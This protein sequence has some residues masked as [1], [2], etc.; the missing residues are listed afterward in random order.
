MSEKSE[1]QDKIFDLLIEL[2]ATVQRT[3]GG[4]RGNIP[5]YF[6]KARYRDDYGQLNVTLQSAFEFCEDLRRDLILRPRMLRKGVSDLLGT[7][8]GGRAYYVECKR[9]GELLKWSSQEQALFLLEQYARGAAIGVFDS[10][11]G[12]EKWVREMSKSQP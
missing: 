1:V 2:D 3:N 5:F 8:P 9:P 6:W 10:P 12:V 4:R 7:L 11:L